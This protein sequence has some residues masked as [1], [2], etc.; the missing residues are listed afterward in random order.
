M[1]S[2]ITLQITLIKPTPNIVFGLQKGTGTNY[3]TVQ[4]QISL[5]YQ[6]FQQT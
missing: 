6:A 2:E 1:E 5:G 3:A 4:K